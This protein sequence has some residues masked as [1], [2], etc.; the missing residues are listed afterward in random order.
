VDTV[1]EAVP[2]AVVQT[3]KCR[4]HKRLAPA[5][6]CADLIS[7]YN[8]GRKGEQVKRIADTFV[9]PPALGA[10]LRELRQRAGLNQAEVAR[11][12]GRT[13]LGAGAMLS[14]LERGEV[15]HPSFTFVV[16]YLRV[17]RA[18][19]SEIADILNPYIAQPMPVEPVRPAESAPDAPAQGQA[20]PASPAPLGEE[21]LEARARHLGLRLEVGDALEDMVGRM[22]GFWCGSLDAK[23]QCWLVRLGREL[24]RLMCRWEGKRGERRRRW[25][26]CTVR[27][28]ERSWKVGVKPLEVKLVAEEVW[29]VYDLMVRTEAH[30]RAPALQKL[31]MPKRARRILTRL[32]QYRQVCAHYARMCDCAMAGAQ[33][34]AAALLE[35]RATDKPSKVR[36]HRLAGQLVSLV[37]DSGMSE[38]ERAARIEE[39]GQVCGDS[40]EIARAAEAARQAWEGCRMRI[41][42]KPPPYGEWDGVL[43][44]VNLPPLDE[45]APEEARDES[46]AAGTLIPMEVMEAFFDAATG[47]VPAKGPYLA[48]A[49]LGTGAAWQV[50]P[51]LAP[52]GPDEADA[53]GQVADV[54]RAGA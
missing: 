52:E 16:D 27:A 32:W 23:Q 45:I 6:T 44:L 10:R 13:G 28:L 1:G 33:E 25:R 54:S 50:T 41:P 49:L 34:A 46:C 14:R 8:I 37:A 18:D 3:A 17:C 19:L 40:A 24:F 9:F 36:M 29:R 48:A 15:A 30:K 42:P 21:E 2:R 7:E 5:V 47:A 22:V 20:E 35:H 38:H 12:M 43:G 4:Y 51:G 53:R 11:L 31:S 26:R 39:L